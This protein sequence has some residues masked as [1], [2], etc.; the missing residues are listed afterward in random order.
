MQV[1]LGLSEAVVTAL[2]TAKN[3]TVTVNF[4]GTNNAV[5]TTQVLDVFLAGLQDGLTPC[6][7]NVSGSSNAT[8]GSTA[9]FENISTVSFLSFRTTF[10]HPHFLHSFLASQSI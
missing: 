8:S 2:V 10:A 1:A 6:A 7:R 5:N 9:Y 3:Y 4:N